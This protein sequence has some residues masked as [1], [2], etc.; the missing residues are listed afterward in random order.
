[1][2][3]TDCGGC[4]ASDQMVVINNGNVDANA[5]ADK[6]LCKGG[7]VL[8][9][10]TP[11]VGATYEWRSEV[12]NQVIS[13]NQSVTVSPIVTTSYILKVTRNGCEDTDDVIVTVNDPP[14]ASAGADVTINCT[15]TSATLTATGG[16]TYKWNTG[17]TTAAITVSPA[18]T[19]TYTVTVTAANGCTATDEVVVTVNKTPPT[20][21]AGADVTVNCTTPSASL[22]AS[23][24]GTYKWNTNATTAA[25]TV[26]P[27]VTTTYTVTVTAANGCT[28]SDEVVVTANKTPPTANAGPDKIICT[29]QSAN[30]IASGGGT[31]KWSTNATTASITVS[32]T[33]ATTYTVT[34]T[35]ANGCTAL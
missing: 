4:T 18:T 28:A 25:I 8:L 15:T 32:P 10:A 22:T 33:V 34:V 7:S 29:G 31:Y 30:L 17:T 13:T 20:A 14:V 2:V 9:S 21:N 3:V 11:V 12:N 24:G 23:G 5:G 26:T 6:L 35:A 27:M 1:M 16:G 19:S